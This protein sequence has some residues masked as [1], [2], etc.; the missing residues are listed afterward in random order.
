[1]QKQRTQTT[2]EDTSVAEVPTEVNEQ[3]AQVSAD[4]AAL[5]DE[6]D[7][8]LAEAEAQQAESDR[9]A[10]LPWW[11][12]DAEWD[13]KT[14]P[15]P[16]EISPIDAEDWLVAN[17]S[18]NV[19]ERNHYIFDKVQSSYVGRLQEWYEIRGMTYDGCTC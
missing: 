15:R 19:D 3:S 13:A 8:L 5:N 17:T 1:M 12:P 2:Q 4:A 9:K 14:A 18:L 6:I 11:H 16:R 10:N 7:E